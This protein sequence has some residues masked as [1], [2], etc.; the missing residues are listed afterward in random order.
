[1]K[2]IIVSVLL[3]ALIVA[4]LCCFS[5]CDILVDR[6]DLWLDE[7]VIQAVV[8]EKG[9]LTVSE[10]WRVST[11]STEGY[12][13]VYKTFG[14]KDEKFGRADEL[15]ILSVKK[16]GVEYAYNSAVTRESQLNDRTLSTC[17]GTYY[18]IGTSSNEYEVGL[19]MPVLSIGESTT[20]TL[21]YA[22]RGFVGAYADTAE[23]DWEIFSEAFEMYIDKMTVTVVMPS[24]VD[25]GDEKNTFFW[26]HCTSES[27]IGGM[28]N[29]LT[30][31]AEK[32]DAGTQVGIHALVPT[33]SFAGLVKT[34]AEDGKSALIRQEDDWQN[35]YLEEQ[36][37]AAKI[38]VVDIVL[39]IVFALGGVV[40]AI[41]SH[42]FGPYKIKEKR[43][44]REIPDDWAVGSMS[45]FYYHY[46]KG[47]VAK[48]QGAVFSA[49][50]LELARRNILDILPDEKEDYLIDVNPISEKES[51]DMRPYEREAF[52]LLKE[53]WENNGSKPFSMKYFEKFA[54]KNPSLVSARMIAFH[55]KTGDKF[56][57]GQYVGKASSGISKYVVI[58][59]LMI[60]LAFVSMAFSELFY[61]FFGLAFG[62]VILVFAS[63]KTPRMK[64]EGNMLYADTVALYNYL[65]D[66][67]NLK[68]Y[69]VPQLVL[70]EEYLVYATMMGISDKVVENLKAAYPELSERG[71]DSAYYR[72]GYLYTYMYLWSRPH[73]FGTGAPFDLGGR[74]QQA[75]KNADNFS[76]ASKIL[77][78]SGSSFGSGGHGGGGFG[79]GGGHGG[80]GGGGR[81]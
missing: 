41:L 69:D 9:D 81:H 16:D 73:T 20:I 50:M 6:G 14:V 63:Y 32:T 65:T 1:M 47:G 67:S 31:T 12:R 4:S 70:W 22:L 21:E 34:K 75:V 60:I 46:K 36:K 54:Q 44:L 39:A 13:N 43:Y 24:S 48:K 58:G 55:K 74:L 17:Q 68:D 59:G 33:S 3:A 52:N 51:A 7:C 37:R 27:N 77:S 10:T 61:L 28:G 57:A 56:R 53:V 8:T 62:G 5:S 71:A 72:R 80:G 78:Q 49:V 35:A 79:G 64:K 19:I 11:S 45:Y 66:F 15:E 29:I 23:F 30:A 38:A 40:G 42:V 76:H 2:K 25:F 18:K 26:L